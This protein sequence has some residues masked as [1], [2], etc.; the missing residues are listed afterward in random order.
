MAFTA[1]LLLGALGIV[2]REGVMNTEAMQWAGLLVLTTIPFA[3]ALLQAR[4]GVSRTGGIL[5]ASH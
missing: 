4:G 2:I 1:L 3:A 5:S